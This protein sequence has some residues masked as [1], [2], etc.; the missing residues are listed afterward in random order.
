MAIKIQFRDSKG[1]IRT[2]ADERPTDTKEK[3]ETILRKHNSQSGKAMIEAETGI[4]VTSAIV[5][6]I[7][8]AWSSKKPSISLVKA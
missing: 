6:V 2:L 5:T 4:K 3:M 7:E 8:G 1:K